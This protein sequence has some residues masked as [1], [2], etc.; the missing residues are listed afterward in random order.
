MEPIG[1]QLGAYRLYE[2]IGGG[3]FANVYF[4]R[5]TRTNQVVAVKVLHAHLAQDALFI[6]RFR[7][8]AETLQKMPPHPNIVRLHEFGQQDGTYYLAMEYLEGKDLS[9]ILA[10]RKRLSVNEALSIVTQIA[11]ALDV[12]YRHG[13]VHRDIKPG[14]IKITPQGVVKVM[15]FGIARAAEGTKLTQSGTF[16]GTPDYIAPEIWEGKPADIRTD[17]YALGVL[18]YEMLTGTTPFHRDTPAAVMRGHLM[19]RPRSVGA[20][21]GDV[22]ANIDALIARMLVKAPEARLQTPAEVLAALHGEAGAEPPTVMVARS[23]VPLPT[24]VR[25]PTAS[26][27]G[28]IAAGAVA[29]AVLLCVVIGA[30]IMMGAHGG[31]T[32]TPVPPTAIARASTTPTP[33]PPTATPIP[34]PTFTPTPRV[35][36]PPT[37]LPTRLTDARGVPMVLVPAGE[38][39]MGSDPDVALA[40]CKKLYIGGDCKREWFEDEYP[41]HTVYLSAFYIDQYEV[42]NA[43]YKQCV[44]VGKCT[45]PSQTKSYTRSSYYGNSQFDNYPVIYVNWEQAKTYCEWRGARLPTEAEW[46]KAARGTDARLYP[47]GNTWDSTKVNSWDSTPRLGDTTAVGSY[48][49][50]ASPYGIMDLAGNVWEW[51][52]DWYDAE[53]Y[54]SSPRNNPTGPSSGQSRV[55][56]GG[57]WYNLGR[58]VRAALRD[59]D[60]PTFSNPIVGFRCARS[61]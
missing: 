28:L 48:S 21:R 34:A 38:F 55:L 16:M 56:R 45:P 60:T 47:W 15:D 2:R 18:W 6:A 13:L 44:D 58:Y 54:A 50:G 51:V 9:Q 40:E 36:P 11:Q 35:T 14:N 43:R 20:Q 27:A 31:A 19:E 32:P 4:A 24:D 37:A 25:K 5:D 42:T 3:G 41:P 7:H 29:A 1:S 26:A 22:P 39:T 30:A 33:V 52:A 17:I 46:E 59:F 57:A 10:E 53:Y 61:P 8:E 23:L 12:A 49:T